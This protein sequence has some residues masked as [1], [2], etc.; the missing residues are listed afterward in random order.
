MN[1]DNSNLLATGGLAALVVGLW[2]QIRTWFS[3]ISGVA[4]I[5]GTFTG[6]V[7]AALMYYLRRNTRVLPNGEYYYDGSLSLNP[8]LPGARIIPFKH[9][10]SKLILFSNKFGP[11]FLHYRSSHCVTI[12]AIRGLTNFNRLVKE[13][14]VAYEGE[15]FSSKKK[16]T[17]TAGHFI[18]HFIGDALT[19][20]GLS[21]RLSSAPE[22]GAEVVSNLSSDSTIDLDPKLDR[23]F[24]YPDIDIWKLRSNDPFDGLFFEPEIMKYV[25]QAQRWLSM[26]D[27]YRARNISWRRGWML[28]GPPGTGKSSLVAALAK[29][30]DLPVFVFH[31][32]TMS[33]NEFLNFFDSLTWPCMILFEDFDNVFHGR[34]CLIP[35]LPLSFDTVLNALSGVTTK[36]GMFVIITTNDLDA[37][38]PAIGITKDVSSGISTRPGRIDTVIHLGLISER[39]RIAMVRKML[40][41]WPAMWDE[42]VSEGDGMTPVQFQELCLQKALVR[43]QEDEEH[44]LG[45]SCHLLELAGHPK[46]AVREASMGAEHDHLKAPTHY[47]LTGGSFE[48]INIISSDDRAG[49]S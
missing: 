32:S 25:E 46:P 28:Y 26:Q 40:Q 20:R 1:F 22:R 10:P 12:T 38:D 39:N 27:F 45:R 42:T 5:R 3:Y 29:K 31:L 37:I 48:L 23:S 33:D 17:P 9:L 21:D 19:K 18:R 41:D 2:Q 13:S 16:K 43:L 47:G 36:N 44:E 11:L 8:D 4:V 15:S 30:L 49:I 35:N 14:L 7:A 34:K 24:L 6:D